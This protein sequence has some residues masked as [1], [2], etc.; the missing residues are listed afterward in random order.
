MKGSTKFWLIASAVLIFSGSILFVGVMASVNWDFR[1]LAT[2]QYVTNSHEITEAFE[3]IAL[4]TD[5]ADI[6]FVMSEDGKCRV[7]CTEEE[8]A[9]HSVAV[10]EGTLVIRVN[11]QRKWYEHIGISI[12]SPRITVYLTKSEFARL[13]VRGS[14]GD[15]EVAKDFLFSEVDI[16]LSTGDVRYGASASGNVRI[17]LSTGDLF[18]E[19]I[20]AGSLEL[21]TS[22]GNVVASGTVCL[23]DFSVHVTTGK[24]RM[25]DVSCKNLTATGSTGDL[26]LTRVIAEERCAVERSTGDIIFER[27]DAAEISV[28]TETGDVTGSLLTGKTFISH[29]DTGKVVLPDS[30]LG[31]RC[32][33]TTD[34]GDIRITV[35]G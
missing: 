10:N 4:E 15:V 33:I 23:G 2:V 24:V 6:R 16:S 14:T 32:E 8:K 13:S 3:N 35:D 29:S 34:T 11:D 27:S 22:T 19:G 18:V 21:I 31:G 5:T 12:G 7:E 30:T 9:T 25:T 20:S 26:L 17:K 28:I 1:R